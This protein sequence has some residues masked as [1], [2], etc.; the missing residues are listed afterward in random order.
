MKPRQK[1]NLT[2]ATEQFQGH[3]DDSAEASNP[4]EA[5]DNEGNPVTLGEAGRNRHPL[6]NKGDR[7]E[8]SPALIEAIKKVVDEA[9]ADAID[10]WEKK[11][12]DKGTGE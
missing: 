12:E 2:D 6:P 11:R 4:H 1:D 8:L 3:D 10:K 5:T 7:L 9:F